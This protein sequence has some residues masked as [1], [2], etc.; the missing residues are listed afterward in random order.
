M[1]MPPPMGGPP[2]GGPPGAGGPPPGMDEG[3]DDFGPS[4]GP[5]G[6]PGGFDDMPPG[7]LSRQ[8]AYMDQRT[9]M[10]TM[11]PV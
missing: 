9:G 2:P 4:P 3:F 6:P 10:L 5:G 1:A 7:E 8:S 11:L